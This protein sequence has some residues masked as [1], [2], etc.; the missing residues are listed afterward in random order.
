MTAIRAYLAEFIG[1]FG[2][3]FMGTSVAVLTGMYMGAPEQAAARFITISFAFGGTLLV[4]AYTVGPVS[5]CHV[6]P[7][8]SLPMA[9]SGRL[10]MARLPGY[11]IA[12][13]LGGIVASLV[14]KFL[15]MTDAT[16]EAAKH[17]LG[18][19][20]NA[21]NLQIVGLFGWEVV[22]TMMF[23]L[24]IFSCTRKDGPPGLA[25]LPIGGFLFLAHLATAQLGD[26]S[27]NPARSLGPALLSSQGMD[28]LWVY[29]T[30]PFAGGLLG[31]IVYKLLY[32]EPPAEEPAKK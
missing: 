31:W 19:N 32:D 13:F 29:L 11:V 4:L 3:V 2:L 25:P 24:T 7:A 1:T 14:L 6:N 27:L 21:H 20:G 23:L 28:V 8:V 18:A 15:V 10:P 26:A 22:L 12:Q 5:G 17:G 30:A 9:L 16:Y